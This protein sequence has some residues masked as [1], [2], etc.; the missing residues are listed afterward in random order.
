MFKNLYVFIGFSVSFAL[1][2][3]VFVVLKQCRVNCKGNI[4]GIE[5]AYYIST[6][7]RY[8]RMWI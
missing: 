8:N 2:F 3:F 4:I 1:L 7:L 6:L 5:Y